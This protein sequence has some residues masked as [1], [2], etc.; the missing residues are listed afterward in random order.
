MQSLTIT[1]Y[2]TSISLPRLDLYPLRTI[3]ASNLS[4]PTAGN[5]RRGMA[6]RR[7]S[8]SFKSLAARRTSVGDDDDD[9]GYC[10]LLDFA[11]NKLLCLTEFSTC[12]DRLKLMF[13]FHV[14][15]SHS[16]RKKK[17]RTLLEIF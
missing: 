14:M 6:A 8:A 2:P 3:T 10:T 5:N 15:H 12:H 4:T 11:G 1:L 7:E 17:T 9:D 16:V 13:V